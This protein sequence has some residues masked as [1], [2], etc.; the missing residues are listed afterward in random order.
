MKLIALDLDGTLLSPDK[1]ISQENIEAIHNMQRMGHIVMISSGR[2][3]EDIK[4]ILRKYNLSCPIAGSNGTIVEVENKIISNT[5]MVPQ[6]VGSIVNMLEE[7]NIPYSLYTNQGIYFPDD[8]TTRVKT[9]LQGI[10]NERYNRFTEKPQPSVQVHFFTDYQSLLLS[11]ELNVNK[12]FILS[13][14]PEK[15]EELITLLSEYSNIT[16]TSSSPVNV[17]IMHRDG[18]KGIGLKRMAEY[19]HIPLE[20]TVAIG[21]NWN[22]VPMLECAGFSIAMDNADD[23]VKKLCNYVTLSNINHGVAHALNYLSRE[24]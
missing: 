24:V 4:A 18:H 15:R 14:H 23:E 6:D 2:A 12:I 1:K 9:S 19:F 16:I 13:F 17:E 20:E 22:D 11:N 21:D 10:T 3:P 7:L 8:W 5:T